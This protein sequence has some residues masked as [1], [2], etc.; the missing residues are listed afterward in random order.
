MVSHSRL[1]LGLMQLPSSNRPGKWVFH[2]SG[3][4]TTLVYAV[5]CWYSRQQQ[6]PSLAVFLTLCGVAFVL[7]LL[8]A[9]STSWSIGQSKPAITFKQVLLWCAIFRLIAVVGEPIYEDDYYRYL[10]DGHQ[11][12]TLGNPYLVPPSAAFDQDLEPQW[13]EILDNINYPHIRTIYGPVNQYL[14]A[15]AY[16]IK[17]GEVWVLQ[18]LFAALDLLLIGLLAQLARLP[19]VVLYGFSPLVV[20]EYSFTAHPDIVCMAALAAATLFWQRQRILTCAALLGVAVSSKLLAVLLVPLLL[21]WNWRAWTVFGLIC[22][23]AYAPFLG[24][25]AI[26]ALAAM[27]RDWLFNAPI[28]FVFLPWFDID[29]IKIALLLLLAALC[30]TYYFRSNYWRSPRRIPRADWLFA[31]ML[32]AIPALNPWYYGL[33]L[34]YATIYPSVWAW[35]GSLTLLFSYA[36][37]LQLADP[38]LEPYQHPTWALWIQFL[39][40]LL[41]L[42]GSAYLRVDR[43]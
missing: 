2:V 24:S 41:A 42:V 9:W 22:A 43:R 21:R 11:T 13:E 25:E 36:T 7:S 37:G 34:I 6:P 1:R 38:S 23:I 28:Y 17:P 40:P 33:V 20:K 10:W 15:V 12:V 5:L 4:I 30:V 8:A 32:L 18:L 26:E 16:W 19:A 39:P 14:F 27:S 35:L 31:A 3:L 29:S